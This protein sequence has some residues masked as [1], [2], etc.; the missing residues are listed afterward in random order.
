MSGFQH[1]LAGGQGKLITA[2]LQSPNFEASTAGWQVTKDGSAQFNNL[3]LL[4]TLQIASND[5]GVF[6]Y[7]FVPG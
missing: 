6:I 7:G 5:A 1:D 4:A 3:S 2:Q